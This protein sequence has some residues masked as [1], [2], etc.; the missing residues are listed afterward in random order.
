MSVLPC[1]S[2]AAKRTR[3]FQ[4]YQ[5]FLYIIEAARLTSSFQVYH[6]LTGVQRFPG[7]QDVV[8]CYFSRCTRDCKVPKMLPTVPELASC[9]RECQLHL[10]MPGASVAMCTGGC[11]VYQRLPCVP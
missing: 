6:R 1:I 10:T 5:R 11:H 9:T 2:E 4:V 8:R 7:M 3:A